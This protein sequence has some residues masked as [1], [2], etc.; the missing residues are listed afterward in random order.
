MDQLLDDLSQVVG[1]SFHLPT[2]DPAATAVTVTLGLR[3]HRM[4]SAVARLTE[5]QLPEPGMPSFVAGSST[6]PAL[7]CRAG[8]IKLLDESLQEAL[9]QEDLSMVS[10]PL[11]QGLQLLAVCN[12]VATRMVP[13]LQDKHSDA[14]SL[15]PHV[16]DD[17]GSKCATIVLQDALPQRLR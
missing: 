1:E 13:M 17:R 4:V 7:L 15:F 6:L 5:G 16:L 14:T 2:E 8:V 12:A 9:Q 11:R 10:V 3:E